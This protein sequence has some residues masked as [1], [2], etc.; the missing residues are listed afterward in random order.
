MSNENHPQDNTQPL[1][2]EHPNSPIGYTIKAQ[3]QE[4][5]DK[6]YHPSWFVRALTPVVALVIILFLFY[7]QL[8]YPA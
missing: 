6:V 8:P 5:L 2:D 4:D 3:P 7:M 1:L